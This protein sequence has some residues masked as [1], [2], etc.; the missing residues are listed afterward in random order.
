MKWC[1]GRGVGGGGRKEGDVGCFC[2]KCRRI[3]MQRTSAVFHNTVLYIT[4]PFSPQKSVIRQLARDIYA[5]LY[6]N[7]FTTV[8]Q[9]LTAGYDPTLC[10]YVSS[11]LTRNILSLPVVVAYPLKDVAIN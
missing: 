4:D 5:Q 8:H 10:I 2:Y 1:H 9:L 3:I 11:K 7:N 6:K